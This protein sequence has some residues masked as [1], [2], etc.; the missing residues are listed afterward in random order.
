[1][2]QELKALR[3]RSISRR[4]I[5]GGGLRVCLWSG[6]RRHHTHRRTNHTRGYLIA[7]LE[8]LADDALGILGALCLVDGVVEVG[9]KRLAERLD[10]LDSQLRQ[11]LQHLLPHRLVAVVD[12]CLLVC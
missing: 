2:A 6:A 11:R 12:A 4:R 10:G 8:T 5:S 3:R 9:V 1:M 7:P